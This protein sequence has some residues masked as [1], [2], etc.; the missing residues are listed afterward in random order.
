MKDK[1]DLRQAYHPAGNREYWIVDAR[2]AEVEFR[3]LHW[4]KSSYVAASDVDGWQHFRV[5][6]KQFRLIRNR[7]RRG[8]WRYELANK[9]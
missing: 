6:G 9:S 8:E 5:F 2:G 4:R 1:R 7:G 3:I